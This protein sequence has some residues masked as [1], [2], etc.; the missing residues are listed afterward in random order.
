MRTDSKLRQGGIILAFLTATLAAGVGAWAQSGDTPIIIS[1]GSLRLESAVPWSQF[2][3]SGDIRTHPHTDKSAMQVEVVLGGQNHP[4][5]CA[6]GPCTVDITYA[7]AH[8][9]IGTGASGKGISMRPFS[10]F[11][12]GETPNMLLH[13]NASSKISHLK[14]TKGSAVAFESDASGGTRI[15]IHYR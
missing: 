8:I 3:G 4:V 7:S 1:D 13:N 5:D 6:G 14:I 2:T 9:V 10:A 15:T 11:R 12:Q